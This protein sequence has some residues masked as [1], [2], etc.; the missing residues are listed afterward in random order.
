MIGSFEGDF[1]PGTMKALVNYAQVQPIGKP[2]E[3]VWTPFIG[4][5]EYS[6]SLG[7]CLIILMIIFIR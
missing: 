7:K 5:A 2:N 1:L 6:Y 4:A 3:Q